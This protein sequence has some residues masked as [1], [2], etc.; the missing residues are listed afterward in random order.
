MASS[1]YH[2][3]MPKPA[4]WDPKQRVRKIAIDVRELSNKKKQ[5]QS[6]DQK[7]IYKIP[8]YIFD[9]STSFSAWRFPAAS[10]FPPHHAAHTPAMAVI[11]SNTAL[12][13]PSA[14][15]LLYM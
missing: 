9:S 12:T 11:T 5:Q 2:S 6:F 4:T 15:A 1:N 8:F 13:I 14:Y 3:T 7:H 10:H